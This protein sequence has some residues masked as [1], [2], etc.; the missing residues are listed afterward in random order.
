MVHKYLK[1]IL[2][3]LVLLTS[4]KG[5][6][7][8]LTSST[9]SSAFAQGLLAEQVQRPK[10][11]F[12]LL[13]LGE[14]MPGAFVALAF[15]PTLP[16][17]VAIERFHLIDRAI[18][19]FFNKEKTFAVLP[20]IEPFNVSG[21]GFGAVMIQ[22]EPL[23]SP[24][25]LIAVGLVRLNGDRSI[26]ANFS[27]RLP[28]LSGRVLE[29]GASYGVDRDRQYYGLGHI[30]DPNAMRLL[31][32]D[33][34]D[35][36][37][38]LSRFLPTDLTITAGFQVAYAYR[39]LLSGEGSNAPSLID[40]G[41]SVLP[42]DFNQENHYVS[43]RAQFGI[44]TRDAPG[45][46]TKGY[47]LNIDAEVSQSV[48][49]DGLGGIRLTG[50]G[51]G[52]FP[53]LARRRVLYLL[54]GVGSAFPTYG[55]QKVPL[56][57]MIRLGGNNRLRGYQDDRFIGRYGWWTSIEYRFPVYDYAGIGAAASL[58]A[59][60][61]KVGMEPSELFEGPIPWSVGIG[62]RAETSLILLGRIQF[63]VSSDGA[64]FSLGF[65]E[66]L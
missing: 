41:I 26:S 64:R 6:S 5:W 3:G 28:I 24:D 11:E 53:I 61:G 16:L 60:F 40:D 48:N 4:S 37:I 43:G 38:G 59:D 15:V 62:F 13:E 19:L 32:T 8:S 57:Q 25:R 55:G 14:S 1:T 36:R 21:L 22:N 42:N 63:A 33:Q 30:E 23:G 58:F 31:R 66:V 54:G 27:R 45:Y 17:L 47:I 50:V 18:N 65:G 9:S 51:S 10:P 44:D 7:Q 20:I 39:H 56:H 2:L 29:L 46:T 12:S 52:F 35:A 34:I 49:T